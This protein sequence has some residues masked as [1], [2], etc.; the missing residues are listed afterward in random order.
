MN[1]E[2]K[3][4]DKVIAD[5]MKVSERYVRRI[6]K[7]LTELGFI[8]RCWRWVR[9]S[10][11]KFHTW[12]MIRA[13]WLGWIERWV[14]TE[15]AK[16]I[17]YDYRPDSNRLKAA[18]NEYVEPFAVRVLRSGKIHPKWI[19]TQEQ[20]GVKPVW[21]T[22]SEKIEIMSKGVYDIKL[23]DDFIV[24]REAYELGEPWAVQLLG[25]RPNL[26]DGILY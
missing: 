26:E 7:A 15:N 22:E 17:R 11:G 16:S 24:L 8:G 21:T 25:V 12:R 18:K 10:D 13:H 9:D 23:E 20:I 6:I 2:F 19:F 4:C 3:I 1:L 14:F 5:E